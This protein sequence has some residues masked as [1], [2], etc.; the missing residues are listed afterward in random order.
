MIDIASVVTRAQLRYTK[1]ILTPGIYSLIK[2]ASLQK[3]VPYP[4]I[5]H[6]IMA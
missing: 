4:A 2:S 5:I 3:Y 6:T 1:D